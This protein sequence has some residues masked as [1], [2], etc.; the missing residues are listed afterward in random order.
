MVFRGFLSKM[1]GRAPKVTWRSAYSFTRSKNSFCSAGALWSALAARNARVRA[2]IRLSVRTR[3]S[4]LREDAPQLR[5]GLGALARVVVGE[6]GVP[7][8]GRVE[9]GQGES[10]LVRPRLRGRAVHLHQVR[11]EVEQGRGLSL[12]RMLVAGRVGLAK[13]LHLLVEGGVGRGIEE[14]DDVV[15][16]PPE[17]GLDEVPQ[18]VR[19]PAVAVH[20]DDL[21]EPVA[22]D[23]IAGGLEQVPHHPRRQREGAGLMA[24]LVDLAV[25][26]V[27]EDDR[28]LFL[29]RPGRPLADVDQVRADGGVG[30][31]LLEDADGED[32]GGGGSLHGLRPIARRQLVPARGQVLGGGGHRKGD[33]EQGDDGP[34]GGSPGGAWL[35]G[36]HGASDASETLSRSTR[37]VNP[38]ERTRGTTGAPAR[39]SSPWTSRVPGP[40]RT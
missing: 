34:H 33:G 6:P 31:V 29:R 24:R 25:E 39:W 37:C 13:L 19:V 8:D 36:A 4:S 27:G 1:D 20:D 16:P 35:R 12:P 10:L 22:A 38:R 18:Q 14:I 28:V 40:A 9:V 3:P 21:L 17:L 30:P 2:S 26:V 32:A 23:L 15:V 7:P 11:T 5:G